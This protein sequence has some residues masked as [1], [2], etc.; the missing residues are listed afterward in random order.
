MNELFSL[1]INNEFMSNTISALAVRGKFGQMLKQIE[2]ER[3]S[4][5]IERRGQPKAV[6]LGIKDYI[7]LA[8]PE[9]EILAAIGFQSEKNKTNRLTMDQIDAVI[10]EARQKNKKDAA[11]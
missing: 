5:V 11:A 2:N 7:K 8:S 4:F 1:N 6:I 3:K 9:P 10:K